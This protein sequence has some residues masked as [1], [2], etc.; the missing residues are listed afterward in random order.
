MPFVFATPS[1]VLEDGGPVPEAYASLSTWGRHGFLDMWLNGET[2]WILRH[3][4]ELERRMIE[5]ASKPPRKT[6]RAVRILDQMA[7][8]LLLAQSSDWAFIITQK[9]SAHYAEMRVRGHV[10]RFFRLEALLEGAS[11]EDED[12]LDSIEAEDAIFPGLDHRGIVN[13]PLIRPHH[14]L[15][16]PVER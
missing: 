16:N 12:F 2:A 8:E 6:R 1:E 7:R 15:G 13:G 14:R 4:H 11:A 9:T 5:H 3:Q 10:D